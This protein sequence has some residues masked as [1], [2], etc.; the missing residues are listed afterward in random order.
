MKIV[1]MVDNGIFKLAKLMKIKS[2][3]LYVILG[4][5]VVIMLVL[6]LGLGRKENFSSMSNAS[7]AVKQLVDNM[8]GAIND[9]TW[10]NASDKINFKTNINYWF[11]RKMLY[12][13]QGGVDLQTY[14]LNQNN[15]IYQV[16]P[17]LQGTSDAS[18][19]LLPR[20]LDDN[21]EPTPQ[22]LQKYSLLD[23]KSSITQEQLN[24][25]STQIENRINNFSSIYPTGQ[26][27]L[28]SAY[29]ALNRYANQLGAFLMTRPNATGVLSFT[30]LLSQGTIS[31]ALFASSGIRSSSQVGNVDMCGDDTMTDIPIQCINQEYKKSQCSSAELPFNSPRTIPVPGFPYSMKL[32]NNSLDISEIP[33][34][35]WASFKSTI[36]PK[37]VNLLCGYKNQCGD[38]TMTNIPLQCINQEYKKFQCSAA[39]LPFNRP[40][41]I[42]VPGFPYS[43][44]L[45]NNSLDISEI[46]NM[47]W[48]SFKSTIV[49]KVA[50]LMCGNKGVYD[51]GYDD[52]YYRAGINKNGRSCPAGYTFNGNSCVQNSGPGITQANIPQ[53]NQDL[54]MLKSQVIPPSNPPG[55]GPSQ[56]QSGA[57]PSG[58][59]PSGAGPSG[60]G[61][62]EAGPS[63]AGPSEAGPGPSSSCSKPTP[64]PPCPPCE[65]CPEPS[66]DCKRV[67]NY[68]S[69]AVNQYIPQP[70][71]AD[72]SQFGM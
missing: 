45:S 8:N 29:D 19:N 7:S 62:S 50:N 64:V 70:V 27:R 30:N 10:I 63:E 26:S 43:M 53:V 5:M 42:P 23:I 55:A 47:N 69:T 36:L 2:K 58:A 33:N 18:G 60:A 49:P 67:P 57:G 38:E 37:V 21:I 34:M 59:G 66:F 16:N 65:R 32:T 17:R 3:L 1:K 68:N 51:D 28:Q 71:L 24:V 13:V 41:T 25:L 44:N 39:E 54:Y 48:S 61:P 14:D 40:T 72:F 12:L 11:D 4:L 9:V 15:Q 56:G 52:G 22:F 6:A 31:P 46:P 35:N 20:Y